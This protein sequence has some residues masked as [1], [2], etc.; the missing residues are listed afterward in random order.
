M[1][2]FGMTFPSS[3]ANIQLVAFPFATQHATMVRAIEQ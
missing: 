3:E 1:R 2:G